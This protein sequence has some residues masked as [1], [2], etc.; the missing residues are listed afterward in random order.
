MPLIKGLLDPNP[1]TRLT[2]KD[3]HSQ[4]IHQSLV[5]AEGTFKSLMEV[6]I[7]E[8]K[9]IPNR[10]EDENYQNVYESKY[11]GVTPEDYQSF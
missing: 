6:K 5:D 11:G 3:A 4:F 8:P 10:N 2:I 7:P 9:I 1:D